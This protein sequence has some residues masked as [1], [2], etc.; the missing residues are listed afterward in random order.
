MDCPVCGCAVDDGDLDR[1][2]NEHL[3]QEQIERDEEFARAQ[4]RLFNSVV[5]WESSLFS[6]NARQSVHFELVGNPLDTGSSSQQQQQQQEQFVAAR[7]SSSR[8]GC[9]W[10]VPAV[11]ASQERDSFVPVEEGFV[12][13]LRKCVV[14]EQQ[15]P[16]AY[17]LT[18]FIDHYQSTSHDLGWGCG[19]RNIQMLSS[20]LL[21]RDEAYRKAL[22]GGAGF[23]PTIAALQQWLEIAWSK[24]FDSD[25][26]EHFNGAIYGSQKWIGTT[27]CAALLRLFGVRAR[28][29]DFKALTRTTGGKVPSKRVAKRPGA[30][31]QN[32]SERGIVQHWNA[33]CD[34]CGMYPIRGPRFSSSK[35][36]DCDLCF[37]CFKNQPGRSHEFERIE[38]PSPKACGGDFE[39]YNHQ[40]LVDWVWNYYTEEDRDHVENRQP[41]VIIS[42][43]PPLY[44]Q[45]QGHSRTIV[46]IQ[47]RRKLGGPEEAFLLVLD[48]SQRTEELVKALRAKTG[49]Q[50]LIK[51]GVHTLKRAAYQVCHIDPGIAQGKELENL[52]NLSSTSYLY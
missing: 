16:S 28:I 39:D 48:P 24:G 14:A 23:V 40:R 15:R 50:K 47:R 38:K 2:V 6:L 41:L 11:I 43:R 19:W 32:D 37:V 25:G 49:W 29:V 20:H 42:R 13:L 36:Q 51:R 34:S 7:P 17:A 31:Q 22:F 3:D 12:D 4:D 18:S 33:H 8:D 52:K 30:R 10:E 35:Q 45:H 21:A 44:F 1:H 26:A 5:E 27:E 9:P 46:G